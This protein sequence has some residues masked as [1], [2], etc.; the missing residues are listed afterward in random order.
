MGYKYIIDI[1]PRSSDHDWEY[2]I[3]MQDG[4]TKCF[5]EYD[6]GVIEN[7]NIS[8]YDIME[9]F[10]KDLVKNP[11]DEIVGFIIREL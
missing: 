10:Q 4:T 7:D 1:Y 5:Y 2:C 9:Q 8:I 6:G 3:A 11:G